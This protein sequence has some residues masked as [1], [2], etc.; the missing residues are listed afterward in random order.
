M[1]L[2]G[3]FEELPECFR[4]LASSVSSA[5]T[6]ALRSSTTF[7]RRTQLEHLCWFVDSVI[8]MESLPHADA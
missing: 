1:S 3:G 8:M 6:L 4:A 5:T 2:E 7:A